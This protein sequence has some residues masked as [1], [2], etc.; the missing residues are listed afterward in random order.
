MRLPVLLRSFP[1][2]HGV[3]LGRRGRRFGGAALGFGEG[4]LEDGGGGFELEFGFLVVAEGAE[5]GGEG[6]GDGGAEDEGPLAG[7]KAVDVAEA[8]AEMRRAKDLEGTGR[9]EAG[10]LERGGEGFAA[11]QRVDQSVVSCDGY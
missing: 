7:Q 9:G 4:E 10:G 8:A 2:H 1:V 3:L 6:V 5:D 11:G